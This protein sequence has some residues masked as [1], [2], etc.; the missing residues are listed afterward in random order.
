MA[1]Y[2]YCS[3]HTIGIWLKKLPYWRDMVF[4]NPN[5]KDYPAEFFNSNDEIFFYVSA[6]TYLH[7]L[8]GIQE[9]PALVSP[10]AIFVGY[11]PPSHNKEE[12]LLPSQIALHMIV[13][14][15][16]GNEVD[17]AKWKQPPEEKTPAI[18]SEQKEV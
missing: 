5:F 2:M 12:Y 17:I 8:K 7:L 1:K 14:D 18:E 11:L 15:R 10:P 16:E 3:T 13:L 6:G 9:N 4:L